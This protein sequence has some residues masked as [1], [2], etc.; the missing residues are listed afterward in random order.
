M[1]YVIALSSITAT[2]IPAALSSFAVR[3]PWQLGRVSVQITLNFLPF[4]LALRRIAMT[5]RLYPWTNMT[6]LFI[7]ILSPFSATMDRASRARWA[8][9]CP[10]DWSFLLNVSKSRG[11]SWEWRV[12]NLVNRSHPAV[13]EI[14]FGTASL[15]ES[16]PSWM[17]ERSSW[18][19][20]ASI[21]S[22]R[23]QRDSIAAIG[24]LLEGSSS[25][26]RE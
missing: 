25:R 4:S 7:T 15:R 14:A 1:A 17:V 19:V 23:A 21:P 10:F 24:M 12:M 6:E 2:E 22:Q 8:N 9:K 26:R 20:F 5:H 18:I 11:S 13:K 16:E 3:R